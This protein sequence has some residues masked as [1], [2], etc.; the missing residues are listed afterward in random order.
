MKDGADNPAAFDKAAAPARSGLPR[1]RFLA[2]GAA[3]ALTPGPVFA[4]AGARPAILA[5]GDS[6]TQLGYPEEVARHFGVPVVNAGIGGQASDAIAARYGAVPIHVIAAAKR[7]VTGANTLT[8]VAPEIGRSTDR[9]TRRFDATIAGVR[10]VYTRSVDPV[11]GHERH[12]FA[13]RKPLRRAIPVPDGTHMILHP[14]FPPKALLVVCAGRN[15]VDNGLAGTRRNIAAIMDKARDEGRHVVLLGV[16]NSAR[17]E[18]VRGTPRYDRIVAL[19]ADLARSYPDNFLD[20]RKAYNG[21]GKPASEQDRQNRDMDVPP[22]SLRVDRL[23]YNA[24]GRSVW[25]LA[26]IDFIK[27]KQWL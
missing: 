6:L 7:L 24:A 21:G 23:H 11:T 5:L 9:V 10:G 25:A 17:P 15:D 27:G 16:I 26:V 12:V 2:L 13:V 3:A 20:I 8:V 14:D 18:E 4:K 1:R 19:N 22:G